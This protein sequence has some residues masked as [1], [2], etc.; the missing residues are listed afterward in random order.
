ML[1]LVPGLVDIRP[2]PAG[3]K[4]DGFKA[5]LGGGSRAGSLELIGSL[6]PIGSAKGAEMHLEEVVSSHYMCGVDSGPAKHVVAVTT[7][8]REDFIRG[9]VC[10]YTSH[11]FEIKD[12]IKEGHVPTHRNMKPAPDA[13][14]IWA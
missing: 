10:S 13:L 3:N 5:S 9:E 1:L 11:A 12:R 8:S 2:F 7:I 6:C 14:L 4:P